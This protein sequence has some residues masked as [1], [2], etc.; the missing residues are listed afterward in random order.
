VRVHHVQPG[1]WHDDNAARQEARAASSA[2]RLSQV[3]ARD[4]S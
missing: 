4:L 2:L 3:T 1:G